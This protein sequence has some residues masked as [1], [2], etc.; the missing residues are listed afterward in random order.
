MKLKLKE[1]EIISF[2]DKWDNHEEKWMVLK[3]NDKGYLLT[4]LDTGLGK[5][6]SESYPWLFKSY[7]HMNNEMIKILYGGN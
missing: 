1:R 3:Y 6:I 5:W 4:S 7:G 2:K